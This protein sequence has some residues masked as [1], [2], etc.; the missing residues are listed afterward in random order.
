MCWV[1][2]ERE[3][4]GSTFEIHVLILHTELFSSIQLFLQ[5]II[6]PRAFAYDEE[7][8]IETENEKWY[9]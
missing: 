5:A 1:C 4:E 6:L 3:E 8:D 9:E 2:E 7:A